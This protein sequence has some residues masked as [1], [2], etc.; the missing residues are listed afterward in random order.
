M[1]EIQIPKIELIP[2]NDLKVDGKNPNRMDKEK[3]E[4]LKK[5]I[6]KFGFIV[7]IITNK[8]LMIADGQNRLEIATELGMKTVPTIRLPIQEID[9]RILRQV[10]N[11]LKGQH[12][13]EKDVRE[14]EFLLENNSLDNLASLLGENEEDFKNLIKLNS[15]VEIKEKDVSFLATERKCPKC[16]YEW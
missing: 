14:F 11:K 16:G 13:I 1:E 8:D 3:R 9:R 12:E 7:P 5:N 10:L 4:A 15:S 2:I 6:Q